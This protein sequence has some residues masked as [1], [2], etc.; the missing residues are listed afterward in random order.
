MMYNNNMVIK[1]FSFSKKYFFSILLLNLVFVMSSVLWTG[2]MVYHDEDLRDVRAGFPLGYSSRDFVG[3]NNDTVGLYKYP[4]KMNSFMYVGQGYTT[5]IWSLF[6]LNIII[7]QTILTPVLFLV[8]SLFSSTQK[9]F[10]FLSVKNILIGLL[11]F[12]VVTF[13]YIFGPSL[14]AGGEVSVGI[15]SESL[16]PVEL[17]ISENLVFSNGI[18][19]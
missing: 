7:V 5:T 1:F 17:P 2:E 6:F 8:H 10:R 16:V 19:E 11:F 18:V 9:L 4:Q 15:P 12:I 14:L 3:G 13:I